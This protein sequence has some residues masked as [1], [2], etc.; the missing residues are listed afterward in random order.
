[1]RYYLVENPL[2]EGKYYAKINPAGTYGEEELI[3]YMLE[4]GTGQS[5]SD[6][7]AV[8]TLWNNS[9]L[10]LAKRGYYVNTA[11]EQRRPDIKGSFESEEDTFDANRHQ[12][13]VDT[14][15]TTQFIKAFRDIS[16]QKVNDVA[17]RSNPVLSKYIDHGSDTIDEVLTSGSIGQL[18]GRRLKVDEAAADEGLYFIAEDITETKIT[19]IVKNNPS[20]IIFGVPEGM[21]AGFYQL[22]VRN[23]YNKS[24]EPRV[25][26]LKTSIEV[27]AVPESN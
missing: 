18:T 2:V 19:T 3:Q 21:A 11:L 20:E 9:I 5:E 24:N 15:P 22:Q 6:I 17:D 26:T 13:K 16:V 14:I 27:L 4:K 23:R 12:I 8:I 1:M 10:E 25:S 7:R